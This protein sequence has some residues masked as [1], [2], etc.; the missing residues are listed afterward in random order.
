PYRFTSDSTPFLLCAE[1]HSLWWPGE[2]ID[3][4][5]AHSL[6]DV[7]AVRLGVGRNPWSGRVWADVIEPVPDVQR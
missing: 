1:C 2:V 5:Q 6:D 7:V 4:A 3:A